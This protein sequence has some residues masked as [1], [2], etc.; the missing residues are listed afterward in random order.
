MVPRCARRF[1]CSGICSESACCRS[2]WR[3][4]ALLR[5]VGRDQVGVGL[6][7]ATGSFPGTPA[8]T[9]VLAY[10]ILEILGS[11]LLAL[12][13]RNNLNGGAIHLLNKSS[14]SDN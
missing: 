6:V 11:L 13:M 7:I 14:A 12:C 9:A 5:A 3:A 8:V 2:G 4:G 10:G 1:V